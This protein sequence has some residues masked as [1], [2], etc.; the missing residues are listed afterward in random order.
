MI[1]KAKG[2]TVLAR[3]VDMLGAYQ[4]GVGAAKRAWAE[5]N[6]S[7]L[8]G[9]IGGYRE[10]IAWLYNRAN[11]AKAIE[12][13]RERMPNVDATMAEAIYGVLLGEQGGLYR[14]A[15]IDMPGVATV[16]KL[17]S[18]YAAPPK[19]LTDPGKYIDLAFYAKAT[20]G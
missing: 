8:V 16:L 12:L 11:K 13:L 18:A 3:A 6:P 19:T 9:F 15:A 14:D 2:F 17:R 5:A 10:G 7:A 1:A 20:Q 4:G